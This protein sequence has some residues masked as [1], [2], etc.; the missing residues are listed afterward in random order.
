MTHDI[1]IKM[2]NLL[3]VVTSAN[4]DVSGIHIT[5]TKG[6][7][8]LLTG[9]PADRDAKPIVSSIPIGETFTTLLPAYSFTIV[10]IK[11]QLH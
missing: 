8:T 6:I 4:I 7:Q 2:V 11:S 10:R 9:N 5:G 3:P 1:I